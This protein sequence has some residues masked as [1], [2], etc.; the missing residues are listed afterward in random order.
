MLCDVFILPSDPR[1]NYG[2]GS[3]FYE[4]LWRV[5]FCIGGCTIYALQPID[6]RTAAVKCSGSVKDDCIEAIVTLYSWDSK[7][8]HSPSCYQMSEMA[9]QVDS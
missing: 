9:V 8:N 1:S 3:H 6:M 7:I 2:F 5:F 4:K